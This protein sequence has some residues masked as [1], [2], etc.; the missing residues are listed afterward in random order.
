MTQTID[1]TAA[2]GGRFLPRVT[3]AG[4]PTAFGRGDGER[5]LI[6]RG[7]SVQ[8]IE[9]STG[10]GAAVLCTV[11]GE[12]LGYG[13]FE[14]TELP[15]I[16]DGVDAQLGVMSGRPLERLA[17]HGL[18]LVLPIDIMPAD[19]RDPILG[20]FI[21]PDFV[22][23]AA[24][25]DDMIE[26]ILEDGGNAAHHHDHEGHCAICDG[27]DPAAGKDEIHAQ[28][29]TI[30][31]S[32]G[33]AVIMVQPDDETSGH[34][35]SVGLGDA[36][37]PELVI[38][39]IYGDQGRQIL[40]RSI[41]WLRRREM[42]PTSGLSI[43]DAVSVPLRLRAVSVPEG[44][45]HARIAAERLG[46]TGRSPD[47]LAVLQVLWPDVSGRFPDEPGYDGTGLPPQVLI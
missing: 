24:L 12:V 30:I 14:I 10:V 44:R 40:N 9:C 26:D 42:A 20:E 32:A 36:G 35:Y 19:I 23:D 2:T 25:D 33:H 46:M 6:H 31:G 17:R 37:W 47:G 11:E 41:E 21:D 15:E 38:S 18:R 22:L 3:D 7:T 16:A 29:E 39:G 13:N 34:A 43:P 27:D 45:A 28:V 8:T 4:E 5:F 1:I